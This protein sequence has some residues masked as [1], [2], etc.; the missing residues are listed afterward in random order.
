MW[1]RKVW[2]FGADVQCVSSTNAVKREDADECREHVEDVV[3]AADPSVGGVR[4]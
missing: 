2:R 4:C 1:N 3:Q